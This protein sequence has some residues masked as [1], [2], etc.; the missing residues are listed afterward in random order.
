MKRTHIVILILIGVG[1][2]AFVSNLGDLS[3]YETV[4]SVRTK[5]G[6]FFR[7]MVTLDKSMPIIYDPINDPNHLEFTAIDKHQ[8]KMRV[9]YND[10]KPVDFERAKEFSIGGKMINDSLFQCSTITLK[11]PSKYKDEQSKMLTDQNKIKSE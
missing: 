9:I 2:A 4:E 11:C 8:S 6:V 1:I 10:A 7:L 5:Q 3:T